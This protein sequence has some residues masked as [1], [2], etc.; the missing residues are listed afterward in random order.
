MGNGVPGN[1]PISAGGGTLYPCD[2]DGVIS[3]PGIGASFNFQ[4]ANLSGSGY[5]IAANSFM[6]VEPV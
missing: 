1:P 5:V 2:V 3:V 4:A 6:E